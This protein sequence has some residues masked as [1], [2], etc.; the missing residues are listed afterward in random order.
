MLCWLCFL[1]ERPSAGRPHRRTGRTGR[2]MR[3]RWSCGGP[4]QWSLERRAAPG[5]P[6]AG[7]R[8]RLPAENMPHRCR[9]AGDRATPDSGHRCAAGK[10]RAGE[11]CLLPSYEEQV[12]QHGID[13]STVAVALFTTSKAAAPLPPPFAS[14]RCA[15]AYQI[16]KQFPFQPG[17]S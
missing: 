15:A 16:S 2:S 9:P 11:R 4:K 12:G 8:R 10:E 7:S 6:A 5:G 1:V 13:A 3:C 14:C 17:C